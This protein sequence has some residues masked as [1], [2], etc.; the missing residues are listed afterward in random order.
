MVLDLPLLVVLTTALLFAWTNGV[1]DAANA[2]ATSVS[3]R[4]L[5]PRVALALAAVLN[6]V[7]AMLGQGIARTVG[8]RIL[9]PPLDNPGLGVVMAGLVGAIVWNLVTLWRGVPSSSS[10]ALIGGLAGAGLAA[11]AALDGRVLITHVVLPMLVSPLVGCLLAWLL[12]ALLYRAFRD[13][14]YGRA[15]HRFRTAQTVSASAM[16]LGHGLQ[17]GQKTMGVMVLALVASGHGSAGTVPWWVR[18][19]AALAL[20]LGTYAGGWRI[21]RT[22][23]R[24][25]VHVD[26]VTGFAS[27]TVASGMLYTAAYMFNAPVSSTHTITASIAGAGA[28]VTGVRALRW[29]VVRPI[30]MAWMVTLPAAGAVAAAVYGLAVLLAR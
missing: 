26:P 18:V 14:I 2:V 22:L 21:I 27:A 20:G 5:T 6:V 23:G 9:T 8:T 29:R 1:H 10:H 16:A 28:S 17:D 25:M 3:T 24:R 4:A 12:M 15:I 7:G 30:I 19:T 11:S 13:A